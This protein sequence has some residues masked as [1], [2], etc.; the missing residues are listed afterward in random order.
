[1]INNGDNYFSL[2]T[3]IFHSSNDGER[4]PRG[5]PHRPRGRGW[6][7]W[8]SPHLCE[9]LLSGFLVGVRVNALDPKCSTAWKAQ[10]SLQFY[11]YMLP[12]VLN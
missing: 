9:M 11:I 7:A 12:P 1:M 8:Q 5:R 6:V 10:R 4:A 2:T 3:A